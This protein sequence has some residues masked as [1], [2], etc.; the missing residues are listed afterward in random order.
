M[1]SDFIGKRLG[2]FEGL[3]EIG[4]GGMGIV[5]EAVQ[6]SLGR[7]VALKVLGSGLGL[8]PKAVDRFRREAAAAARLHHT[9]IVPVYS[10][11][12]ECGI[13]FYAMELIDGPSLDSVIR[14]MRGGEC[15]DT[16]TEPPA[17]FDDTGP[18]VP[19]SSTPSPTSPSSGIGS[20]VDRFDRT[21]RMISDVA[22]ALQHA[23]QQGVTHRDIK[24]SNLLLS[25]D[26]RL[27]VTDFGLARMLELP[28]MTVTGE[29]VGTPAYMSPEQVAAGR[30]PVDHRTDI[31]S[32]GATLYELLTL[33]RPFS[34]DGRDRLLA[35]VVHKEP[36]APRSIES[37]IPRDLET[38]CLKSL[39]K[40]PDR[41]YQTAKELADD[42]RRYINRF[43]IQAKRSGPVAKIK[44]WVKR[45]PSLS[46]TGLAVVLAL[47]G[48]GAFA[49]RAHES[50]ERRL[51]YERKRDAELLLEKQ[52]LAIERGMVAA[53][54]A[55]LPSAEKAV[56]EA[57]LLG[58][59]AG[60]IRML[61]GFMAIYSEQ[62]A[63][64]ISHLEQSVRLLPERVAPRALLAVA[65]GNAADWVAARRAVSEVEA[66]TPTTP[67]DKLFKGQAVSLEQP[68][69]GI[70]L[71][72]EAMAERRSTLGHL[73]LAKGRLKLAR[74]TGTIADAKDAVAAAEIAKQLLPDNPV[75]HDG[76]YCARMC[77]AE[78]Y[79]R[80]GDPVRAAEHL[81]EAQ[82]ELEELSSI[83]AQKTAILYRFHF[84]M[85]S[86][87]LDGN[88]DYTAEL[89]AARAGRH[90]LLLSYNEAYNWLCLGND[91]NAEAL[92]GEFPNER[93]NCQIRILTA[94]GRP[95]G[96]EAALS[97]LDA[98]AGPSTTWRSRVEAA[99][100]LFAL[101][102][103]R[104]ASTVKELI[105]E[106]ERLSPQG[107]DEF[108]RHLSLLE[109]SLSE[110]E[111]LSLPARGPV[112]L[113]NRHYFVA[114]K[115]LGDGD[116]DGARKAFEEAYRFNG[117]SQAWM[118]ARAIA[119]RMKDT[120]WPQAIRIKK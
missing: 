60:E 43:A 68:D 22:D 27:S 108:K 120:N 80:A 12:E 56:A 90:D 86:N 29:F 65:Y 20:S 112:E 88:P 59:S 31:Y 13:H 85:L 104:L 3:R 35:M 52:Q 78:S 26:G 18:Y 102:R 118:V 98:F 8:T 2:D 10:T 4:R 1:T 17:N 41:R 30:I 92:A 95:D 115:R 49:W 62:G 63:E 54:A 53:L 58:A 7:R 19:E 67:E 64:A 6:T 107:F 40:D 97:A 36:R 55:D 84:G 109:G 116:R 73:M 91:H 45:N 89:R 93:L 57:E 48:V 16:K 100:F 24:P 9:N 14:Q 117:Y 37:R 61:R 47:C 21:A 51:A 96:R 28:G 113:C 76:S 75:P 39:E 5:Y 83:G 103:T 71:I 87:G 99:P 74:I 101:N 66:M 70:R 77:A 111:L 94:L 32:L 72:N 44:K 11:G 105:R 33:R 15:N 79:K 38:I 114:W 34:A 69:E 25:S 42:L 50:E 82:H 119:I 110:T 81:A 106:G 23:H 46:V